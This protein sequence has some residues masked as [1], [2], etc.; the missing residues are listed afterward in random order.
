MHI[1]S[2]F[3]EKDTDPSVHKQTRVRPWKYSLKLMEILHCQTVWNLAEWRESVCKQ[4]G[5]SPKTSLPTQL[6]SA[7]TLT[8]N[9]T[10][11][12]LAR[13]VNTLV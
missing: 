3:V 1:R 5:V 7:L 4:E 8:Y 2:V 9:Y 10:A 13:H 12:A 6:P 11:M